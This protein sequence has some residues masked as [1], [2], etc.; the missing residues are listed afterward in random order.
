MNIVNLKKKYIV[1]LIILKNYKLK[2][3]IIKKNIDYSK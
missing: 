3:I 2:K 1:L